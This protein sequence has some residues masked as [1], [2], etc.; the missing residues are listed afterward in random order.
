MFALFAR[1]SRAD[2]LEWSQKAGGAGAAISASGPYNASNGGTYLLHSAVG[3]ASTV[4]NASDGAT[5]RLNT[6]YLQAFPPRPLT[7]CINEDSVNCTTWQNPTAVQNFSFRNDRGCASNCAFSKGAQHYARYVYSQNATESDANLDA[8]TKWSDTAA[9]CPGGACDKTGTTVTQTTATEGNWYL[10]VRTYNGGLIGG[11]ATYGPFGVDRTNPST[12]WSAPAAADWFRTNF[13]ANVVDSDPTSGGVASGVASCDVRVLSNAVETVAWSTGNRTCNSATSYAVT[14][15]AAANCKDRGLN[16][17]QVEVRARDNAGNLNT[18]V[19]RTFSID[20][21]I[22]AINNGVPANVVGFPASAVNAAPTYAYIGTYVSAGDVVYLLDST[23]TTVDSTTL[24]SGGTIVGQF[25]TTE[26]TSNIL[27]VVTNNGKLYKIENV[28]GGTANDPA[29]NDLCDPGETVP[30]TFSGTVHK[31]MNSAACGGASNA[32]ITSPPTTFTDWEAL[33]F[34]GRDE[35]CA[36]GAK[37]RIY[38]VETSA[39]AV[40]ANGLIDIVVDIGACGATSISSQPKV[41]RP[42]GWTDMVAHFGSDCPGAANNVKMFRADADANAIDCNKD[43]LGTDVKGWMTGFQGSLYFGT[44]GGSTSTRGFYHLTGSEDVACGT[45]YATAAGFPAQ[46]ME[47][48]AGVD[49]GNVSQGAKLNSLSNQDEAYFVTD[50]GKLHCACT[51]TTTDASTCVVALGNQCSAVGV[52]CTGFPKELEAGVA[53]R[54]PFYTDGVI[55][56]VS[57]SGRVYAVEAL[58]DPTADDLIAPGTVKT[59]NGY[60]TSASTFNLGVTVTSSTALMNNGTKK[61]ALGTDSGKIFYLPTT[62]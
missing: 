52:S 10:H 37:E 11:L 59:A 58:C 19:S 24:G 56:T 43:V 50:D 44:M 2:N 21:I 6:Q 13:N 54:E 32:T 22:D 51:K 27:W 42:S 1:E 4:T 15:G 17:C 53:L 5:Y 60:N 20:W 48:P 7:Q 9:F 46:D 16:K 18:S 57:N 3:Q 49:I 55:Y 26:G 28:D 39:N 45:V 38:A 12:A 8:G 61:I 30:C 34:A 23:A 33:W 40:S 25:W 29:G 36:A 14:V 47:A 31:Q 62:P 35:D 41:V